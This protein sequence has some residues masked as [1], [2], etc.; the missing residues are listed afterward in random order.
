MHHEAHSARACKLHHRPIDPADVVTQKQYAAFLRDVF[1][2]VYVDLVAKF[3]KRN[4]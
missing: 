2:T 1:D 4:E 3:H